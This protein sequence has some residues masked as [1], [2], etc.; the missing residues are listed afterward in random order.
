MRLPRQPPTNPALL[1]QTRL[2]ES[3]VNMLK[4]HIPSCKGL[5]VLTLGDNTAQLLLQL[6]FV[7]FDIDFSHAYFLLSSSLSQKSIVLRPS[8]IR[9]DGDTGADV[10]QGPVPMILF[11]LRPCVNLFYCLLSIT[12]P[13][14]LYSRGGGWRLGMWPRQNFCTYLDTR[15]F[16]TKGSISAHLHKDRTP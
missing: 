9:H 16:F 7:Y 6:Y 8:R 11:R 15:G 14:F 13:G 4:Y 5:R 3:G 10:Q 1:S 2:D 12:S